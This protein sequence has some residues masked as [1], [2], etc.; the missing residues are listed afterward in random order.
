MAYFWT[1]LYIRGAYV[2]VVDVGRRLVI[3]RSGDAWNSVE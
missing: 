1:T 2:G 3:K